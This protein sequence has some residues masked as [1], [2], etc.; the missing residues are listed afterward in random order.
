MALRSGLI[1]NSVIQ[2]LLGGG[3]NNIRNASFQKANAARPQSQAVRLGTKGAIVTKDNTAQGLSM[4]AKGL[5]DIANMRKEKAAKETVA[6][7]GKALAGGT[8]PAFRDPDSPY[9]FKAGGTANP[10]SEYIDFNDAKEN[11]PMGAQ[12][13][14]I[15]D[16]LARMANKYQPGTFKENILVPE[17]T[18]RQAAIQTQEESHQNS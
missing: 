2:G 1:G 17:R 4:L 7:A 11:L 5:S 8:V 10:E 14:D 16:G 6:A 13:G 12:R 9:L 15:T 18:G 3:I